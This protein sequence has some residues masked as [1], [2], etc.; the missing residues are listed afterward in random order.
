MISSC[1][2][3]KTDVNTKTAEDA[4]NFITAI[5]DV[6]FQIDAIAKDGN[7]HL[8]K[9][10]NSNPASCLN[11]ITVSENTYPRNITL[12]FGPSNCAGMDGRN[13]RGKIYI[14]TSAPFYDRSS[15]TSVLFSNYC[16]NDNKVEGRYTIECSGRNGVGNLIFA[17]TVSDL[18]ILT[19]GGTI[20][21]TGTFSREW[22]EGELTKWPV[23]IDDEYLITGSGSG[24]S[25]G[26]EKFDLNII[27][28]LKFSVACSWIT[29]GVMDIES[30]GRTKR[31]ID[32]GNSKCDNSASITIKSDVFNIT[33]H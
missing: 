15:V 3:E 2:E 28:P 12:D 17:I 11:I 26:S 27:N 8:S 13:R 22:S 33:L 19:P 21:V 18:N 32:Y 24:S 25:S 5:N 20:T 1:K 6:F 30:I 16:I 14:S 9:S 4:M 23:V 10:K 31:T 29:S 7:Y